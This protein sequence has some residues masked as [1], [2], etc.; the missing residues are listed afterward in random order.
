VIN[1][2]APDHEADYVHRLGRTGRAGN[3]GVGI[4]FLE[5]SEKEMG[6]VVFNAMKRSGLQIPQEL[7]E[8]CGQGGGKR[9]WGFGG[10]GFKFDKSEVVNF[11]ETRKIERDPT[12]RQSDDENQDTENQVSEIGVGE[13][14]KKGKD[15]K[16]RAEFEINDFAAK[17]RS[18]LTKKQ[19]LDVVMEESGVNVIQRGLFVVPGVRV[20][21]GERKLHLLIEGESMFAVQV[22]LE[23]LEALAA[24]GVSGKKKEVPVMGQKYKV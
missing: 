21:V 11:R 13:R 8:M 1:Y 15:G 14:I 19:N 6:L 23:N 18:E 4:T 10:H 3:H 5:K 9:K 20:P 7:E 22:A 12:L 17:M 16:W 24:G 2:D